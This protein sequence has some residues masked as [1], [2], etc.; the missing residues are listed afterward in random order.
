MAVIASAY[1]ALCVLE[2]GA[3]APFLQIQQALSI[4]LLQPKI[5][6]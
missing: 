4:A 5:T 6:E 3:A 1:F 2:C